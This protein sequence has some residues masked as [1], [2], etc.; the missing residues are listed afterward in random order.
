LVWL[1]TLLIPLL[2]IGTI[3]SYY[4]A[5][6]FANLAYD[7]SLF[8]TALA[9]ADQ[10]EVNHGQVK[11]DLPQIA[12]DLL[13]YDKDDWIYYSIRGPNGELVTGQPNLPLPT[14]LPR[15]D[16][17]LYY[18]AELDGKALRVVAF[19]LPLTGTSAKGVALVLVAETRAKRTVMAD[20]IIVTMMLPQLL[21]VLL[22]GIMVHFGV[23]RGLVTLEKLRAAFGSRS[24]QDLSPVSETGAP[25]E[26]Q[27][28]LHA[29]NDLM[30]RLRLAISK[31][32]RFI[33]DASHQLRTPLA[34]LKT[35]AELALREQ[36]P[37]QVQHALQQIRTSS[38][39]LDHMV[40]QL[41]SL[42][43]AEPEATE[44]MELLALDL[45][46]L[47]Q[48]IT[49]VW[50]PQALTKNIDLG[51][52]C[53][54]GDYQIMGNTVLLRELVNNLI[55]NAIRYTPVNGH[56]TV[57]VQQNAEA[58]AIAVEDNG[59]GIPADKRERVFERFYRIL[60]SG[61]EGCGLGL[62]IVREIAMR[63][64]ARVLIESATQGTGTRISVSFPRRP[65]MANKKPVD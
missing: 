57:A 33:A 44:N 63:H 9:L 58:V 53:E 64:Q 47:A 35:Q 45:S 6:H 38:S 60:G 29:M 31:Q 65:G 15:A 52:A 13:E 16:G 59:P 23:G 20:E 37:A 24:L 17:H 51:F 8:R 48:E 40:S 61:E 26:V 28:L 49:G 5:N 7:R 10:I 3:A 36:D 1:L 41:L 39:N 11:A 27:P 14:V 32:Q 62:T 46:K 30:Q 21:I 43:R 19:A 42:A 25:R 55:D 2:L 12:K 4:R 34:G 56:I 50:V 22:A 18:D 54:D